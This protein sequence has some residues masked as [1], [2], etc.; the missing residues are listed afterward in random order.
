MN[1]FF[2]SR[3]SFELNIEFFCINSNGR[4]RVP[5]SWRQTK[6]LN[7]TIWSRPLQTWVTMQN[8]FPLLWKQE[9]S[10]FG[11][12][13][14]SSIWKGL[15]P[16]TLTFHVFLINLPWSRVRHISCVVSFR[17]LATWLF[18]GKERGWLFYAMECRRWSSLSQETIPGVIGIQ[19]PY[20]HNDARIH[21]STLSLIFS[22]KGKP[23]LIVILFHQWAGC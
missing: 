13:T 11:S 14:A 22:I 12:K 7:I 5:F 9:L 6:L 18:C 8:K 1:F 3:F 15:D 16:K 21:V 4:V 23:H 10:L 2:V 17:C 20:R 19:T